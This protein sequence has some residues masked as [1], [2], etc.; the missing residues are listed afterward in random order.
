MGPKNGTL[1][2]KDAAALKPGNILYLTTTHFHPEHA[3]GEGGF[4]AGTILVRNAAQQKELEADNGNMLKMFAGMGGDNAELL[5]GVTYRKPD[6]TFDKEVTI[7]LGGGVTARLIWAG[8]AHTQGDELTYVEPDRTLISG[9]VIQNKTLPA[10]FGQTA[11]LKNWIN[12]LHQ[13]QSMVQPLH[14]VPDHS[15]AG[16]GSLLT[17]DL[18]FYSDLQAGAL[19]LKRQGKAADEAGQ[20]VTA[21]LKTKYPGW[22]LD[23]VPGLVSHV[24]SE[25]P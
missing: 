24:Y 1:A 4:P 18:A 3:S 11:S 5:K 2:A 6:V 17:E 13:L 14:I 21:E 12:T 15:P 16:D 8:P 25:N 10:L 20:T 23:G 7:D 9:D 19:D 22:P